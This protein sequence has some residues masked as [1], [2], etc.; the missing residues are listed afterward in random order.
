MCKTQASYKTF[1]EAVKK[2]SKNHKNVG[3]SKDLKGG[4]G[5]KRIGGIFG[6]FSWFWQIDWVL[7]KL[8]CEK[9]ASF[10]LK[11]FNLKGL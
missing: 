3:E 9:V 7:L 1:I 4:I 8:S 5:R 2:D 6:Y 10:I 11:P